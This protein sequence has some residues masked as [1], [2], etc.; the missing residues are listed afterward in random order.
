VTIRLGTSLADTATAGAKNGTL[1]IPTNDADEASYNLNLTG[2]VENTLI[3]DQALPTFYTLGRTA[4]YAATAGFRNVSGGY[5]GLSQ[6][7]TASA[8]NT[9]TFTLNSL[10]AGTYKVSATWKQNAA[11]A[12]NTPFNVN[13]TG[14]VTINQ[15]VA[16][17]SLVNETLNG[18]TA[19]WQDLTM[20]TIGAGGSITVVVGGATASKYITADAIRVQF[21]SPQLADAPAPGAALGQTITDADLAPLF[22]EA[23]RRWTE[24]EPNAAARLAD[25]QIRVANLPAGVLGLAG[26]T[27]SDI[28]LSANAAGQG[29]FV[30]VT[31]SWDEEFL[32]G[33]APAGF[34]LLSTLAHE[35]GHYLGYGDRD[36]SVA[37]GTA[38]AGELTA[39]VRQLPSAGL[40]LDELHGTSVSTDSRA[41]ATSVK[42][43]AIERDELF[44]ELGLADWSLS[45][46]SE[47]KS[48]RGTEA[49]GRGRRKAPRDARDL[50]DDVFAEWE[51]SGRGE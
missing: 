43:A 23:V 15:Q 48:P 8:T 25:A 13:G 41:T 31:P 45:A 29:W 9:A 7:T 14:V 24:I 28:W 3:V 19:S 6:Y 34:D 2:Y 17:S 47:S 35:L 38:M 20:V 42:S 37:P 27:T 40:S 4:T 51:E 30:D 18:Q 46:T 50:R 33:S 39:G 11:W 44:A 1:A 12:T 16:P 36:A 49:G 32:G 21:M 5:R 26:G 22:A 10:P